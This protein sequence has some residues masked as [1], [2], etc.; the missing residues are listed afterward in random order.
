MYVAVKVAD[1]P[2]ASDVDDP[3]HVPDGFDS[4][5]H[6]GLDVNR[7]TGGCCVAVPDTSVRS[8]FPVLVTVNV[9]VTV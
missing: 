9:Y 1:C 5:T 4:D 2:T 8:T 3:E 7:L 6:V